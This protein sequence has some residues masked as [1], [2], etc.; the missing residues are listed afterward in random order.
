METRGAA[1]ARGD[2]GRVTLWISNKGAEDR[3]SLAAMLGM[4]QARFA[5]RNAG[6]RRRLRRE[7]GADPE[8]AVVV[9]AARRSAV[10]FAGRRRVRRTSCR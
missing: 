2:D 10:R 8:Q 7:V 6:G 1:A 4:D 3:A 9:W 5:G